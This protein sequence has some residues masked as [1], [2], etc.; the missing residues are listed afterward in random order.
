Y[1]ASL[2]IAAGEGERRHG[3]ADVV[4]FFLGQTLDKSEQVSNWGAAELTPSQ[5]EYAARDAAIMPEV[6]EKLGERIAAEG[7]TDVLRL[8]NECVMPIAEMELSGFYL[9]ESRWREQLEKVR[10]AQV[11]SADELQDMLSAGV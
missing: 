4:Q 1:L 6:R 11:K 7:L 9:D 3:L 8:E 10:I 2:L 5:I